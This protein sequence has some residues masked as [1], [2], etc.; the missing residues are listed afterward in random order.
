[1]A[2]ARVIAP[3]AARAAIARLGRSSGEKREGR[4]REDR[5]RDALPLKSLAADA[6]HYLTEY[7]W[8]GNMRE[9]EGLIHRALVLG[10]GDTIT[11]ALLKQIHETNSEVATPILGPHIA[12]KKSNGL[13]KTMAEIEEE[14]MRKMLEQYENNITRAAEALGMAKSTF[15][16]KIKNASL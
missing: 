2:Q 14:A 15:Y 12:L 4:V 5:A 6:R 13:P 1:M 8:P 16:R 3:R 10:E 7:A 9:L 11:R